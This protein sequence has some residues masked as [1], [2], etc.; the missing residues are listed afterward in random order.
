VD[1]RSFVV[2]KPGE[3]ACGD[4]FHLKQ[5]SDTIQ[6]LLGDGLGHGEEAAKAVQK[7]IETFKACTDDNAVDVLRSINDG[8]KR[9]RGLVA[10]VAIFHLKERRWGICGVGNIASK[11]YGPMGIKNHNPYNGIVGLNMPN[12]MNEQVMAYEHGQTLVLCS[13]G[14]RSK[15]DLL[16][17]PG[18]LRYDL[19]LLNAALFKEFAR[20]TDDMSVASCKITV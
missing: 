5:N 3:I 9:T 11:F 18:I 1:A 13:D 8:V 6:I 15:W 12:T 2:P 19:S 7:A 20:N 14:I 16:K 4:G 17:F 10:T